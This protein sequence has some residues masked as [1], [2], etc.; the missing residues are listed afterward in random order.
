MLIRFWGVRGSIPCPG[1]STAR[2]G[3]NTPCV[4]VRC[5]C[6]VLIFD[7]GTGIRGLGQALFD[8]NTG[9]SLAELLGIPRGRQPI[10][11]QRRHAHYEHDDIRE[12]LCCV[13]AAFTLRS[14]SEGLN[15]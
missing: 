12:L 9:G 14:C 5:G 8:E 1:P 11:S 2:Y 4:E 7:A 10:G 15:I 6:Q 3:G 13:H